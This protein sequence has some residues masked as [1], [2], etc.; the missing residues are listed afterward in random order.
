MLVADPEQFAVDLSSA[1]SELHLRGIFIRLEGQG[2]FDVTLRLERGRYGGRHAAGS[3]PARVTLASGLGEAAH[4][5]AVL[6]ATER[7][8]LVV[9]YLLG[10]GAAGHAVPR[11]AGMRQ[12]VKLAV[13]E[14]ILDTPVETFADRHVLPL[15][16]GRVELLHVQTTDLQGSVHVQ[17]LVERWYSP[18][19]LAAGVVELWRR[20]VLRFRDVRRLAVVDDQFYG[21]F[22]RK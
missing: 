20:A 16:V 12:V 13:V 4:A 8:L 9:A 1:E 11:Q 22:P 14:Q 17:V 15:V 7:G 2:V 18:L 5:G 6:P 10:L 3:G 21:L 19:G